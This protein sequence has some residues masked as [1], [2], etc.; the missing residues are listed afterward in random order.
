MALGAD[1]AGML[2]GGALGTLF[3]RLAA[4]ST[5]LVKGMKSSELAVRSGVD[6][7]VGQFN[8]LSK[9][10][11]GAFLAAAGTVA[12]F[13]KHQIDAADQM[14]KTAQSAGQAVEQ[15]SALA[16]A[17]SIANLGVQDLVQASKFLAVWMEKSGKN[18]ENLTEEIIKQA[19][20]FA[21]MEDGAA[22]VR[23]AI[24]RFGRAGASIIPFLNAGS[25]AIRETMEEAQL[26]GAVITKEFSQN[27]EQFNDN[28]TRINTAFKGIFNVLA[29]EL[30]PTWI[31]M[32]ERF[33]AWIKETDAV[34]RAAGF[35]LEVYDN[36]TFAIKRFS[37]GVLTVWTVL[38][39]LGT[40]I[41]GAVAIAFE[42]LMNHVNG[43]I[44]LSKI[45]FETTKGVV[46]G[47][48]RM[49]DV[50]ALAGRA[51][52][53]AF[54]GNFAE[55]AA[56]ARAIPNAL[57]EGWDQVAASVKKG[58][59]DAGRV[60]IDTISKDFGVVKAIS[61]STVEDLSAQWASWLET[62]ESLLAPV[63]IRAK[64]LSDT[65]KKNTQ[66]IVGNSEKA[67]E[68]L[69]KVGLPSIK[70]MDSSTTQSLGVMKEQ[71]EAEA[72]IK[73][74]E[75]FRARELT[76]TKEANAQFQKTMEAHYANL[77]NLQLNQA[78]ITLQA[79]QGMFD[80]LGNAAKSFAGEQSDIYKTM[81][82][83]SKA[84]AIAESIVKIQQGVANALSLPFPS[85][86]VAAASVVAAAANI[87]ST[88]SSINL[89][90]GGG[91]AAGGPVAPGKAFLVG[92]KGPELFAPAQRGNIVPNH[93]LGGGKTT[94][95]IH[96]YTDARATVTERDDGTGRIIE[97]VLKRVKNEVAS[98]V[99][100]GRGEVNKAMEQSFGLRRG[101]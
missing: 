51:V 26:F 14:G 53:A 58:A 34:H 54:K 88:I 48:K 7:M 52:S 56:A 87:V 13:T 9:A 24:E 42:L 59:S 93:E 72:K 32:Q 4:D 97:V 78:A 23:M 8:V 41:G 94:V 12:F 47:L 31:D 62:G 77:R 95:N 40:L 68:L 90:F 35:L 29:A 76:L 91:K 20:E 36:L 49:A 16:F 65:I 99:R 73:V 64:A 98:E 17:A 15:F 67:K 28:L 3:V 57:G 100:D 50:A 45:W 2:G 85:N 55:A 18:V 33:I 22:K 74:L 60:V 83:A 82:A 61:E 81:F 69:D 25:A 38:K 101:R 46:D 30:L 11:G 86:I 71:A 21:K 89:A 66:D 75:D 79:G 44:Q 80:A 92:E 1:M 84:F 27:S 43:V 70:T 39:S 6:K 5:S 96:N 19:D 63:E 37:L 10:A